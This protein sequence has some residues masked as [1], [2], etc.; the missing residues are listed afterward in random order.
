MALVPD[1]KF[2]TFQDG[3]NIAVNDIV[4]GL[5]NGLN[6]RFVYTGELPSGVII[7][8]IQGGT[9]ANNASDARTNLGLGTMAVQNASSVAI[10]GGTAVLASGTVASVPA[11]GI[12]IVNKTYADTLFGSGVI[13]GQGT[14][15]QV[16]VNGTFGS[17]ETGALTFTLP[18][19]I[20]TTSAVQFATVRLGAGGLLDA[21]GVTMLAFNAVG[22]ATAWLT[23]GNAIAP[24]APVLTA[25]GAAAN[26]PIVFDSKGNSGVAS[27]GITSGNPISTGYIGEQII[28]A[29]GFGS[30]T[31]I[32][33]AVPTNL[34]STVV[35][36]GNWSAHGNISFTGSAAVINQATSWISTIS[37]TTPDISERA[38][39]TS[40]LIGV[41]QIPAKTQIFNFSVATTVYLTGLI[42]LSAG[43]CTQCGTMQ[44]VR[45]C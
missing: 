29:V 10:T 36:A 30:A 45:I 42:G 40:S 44:L 23:I 8:I 14:A 25:T 6:T 18:Q 2:S 24:G 16:L 38:G 7:P 5:R 15:N 3:G 19:S 22:S 34:L 21:N 41:A 13:S 27:R 32:N 33:S 1:Q 37:A 31:N 9:G 11:A 17:A 39:F 12:D 4:V 35:P 26:I 28:V 43:T 20:A